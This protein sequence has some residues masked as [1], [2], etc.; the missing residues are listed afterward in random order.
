M[1]WKKK[2]P[3]IVEPVYL[4]NDKGALVGVRMGEKEFRLAAYDLMM[5]NNPGQR[6]YTCMTSWETKLPGILGLLKN[7]TICCEQ[8][9]SHNKI[10]LWFIHWFCG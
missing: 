7:Q 6:L 1:F 10:H 2:T 5:C 3:Q 4:K 9:S 8:V